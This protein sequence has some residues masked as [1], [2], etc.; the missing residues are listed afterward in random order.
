M[1]LLVVGCG[2]GVEAAVLAQRLGTVVTGIDIVPNFDNRAGLLADLREGDA[3]QMEFNDESFD[4]V[5]SFHALEHIT[6]Y[7]T[8][9][10]EM[11]RVLKPKGGYLIG[12]PNRSR[13]LGYLGSTNTP[14]ADK[15]RW[16]MA[17]WKARLGG[18][19]HNELGAHAGYTRDELQAE[20]DR[21]FTLTESITSE[22]YLRLYGTRRLLVS[23]LCHT[24]LS[25]WLFPAIY[26]FM[27]SADATPA[28]TDA[29]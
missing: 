13:L 3:M 4:F 18:E 11:H 7:R 23:S 1:R 25:R 24:G 9:L 14:L 2:S 12:T 16:N 27:G 26:F 22:Y 17:D 5:Y 21:V 15:V 8:A 10:R 6:D 28:T 20:L 29:S 19:F